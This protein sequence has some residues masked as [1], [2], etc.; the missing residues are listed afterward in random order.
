[1]KAVITFFILI[2]STISAFSQNADINILKDINK[3]R[4]KDLDE[5]FRVITNSVTP[6][7]IA[8]PITVLTVGFIQHDSAIK[9]KGFCIASSLILAAGISSGLKYTVK[10]PRPFVTYSFIEKAS[11][12]GSPS[13]PSGHTSDAFATATS[14]SLAFP[15]WYVLIPSYLW[16][17]SV[18]YSRMHLGVHYPSDVLGGAVVGAGTA[19]LCYKLNQRFFFKKHM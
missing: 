10:R 15:K 8:S 9:N 13:F 3:G 19:F 16:A 5:S 2:V 17:C 6:V 7:S 11:S 12:G 18:G 14:L 1:M 4:N